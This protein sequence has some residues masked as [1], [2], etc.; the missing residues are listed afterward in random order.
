MSASDRRGFIDRGA[1][2]PSIRRQ[3]ALLEVARS[4]VYRAPRPANDND[5]LLTISCQCGV[6]NRSFALP[7]ATVF[8]L[9]RDRPR[10]LQHFVAPDAK[11]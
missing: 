1:R 9:P 6:E 4:G 8:I 2:S 11:G 5:L 3:W 10:R 7:E